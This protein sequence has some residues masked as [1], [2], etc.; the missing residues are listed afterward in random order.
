MRS[1]GF[2]FSEEQPG[3]QTV[4]F[5]GLLAWETV[6][7]ACVKPSGVATDW[8]DLLVAAINAFN[9]ASPGGPLTVGDVAIVVRDWL[10]GHGAISTS[11]PVGLSGS[12]ADKIVALFGASALSDPITSVSGLESKLRKMCGIQLEAP[13]FQLAGIAPTGLG[14]KPRLRVCNTPECSYQQMCE[15]LRPG[16]QAQLGPKEVLICGADSVSV[17]KLPYIDGIWV[18]LCP[19]AV[20]GVIVKFIPEGCPIDGVAIGGPVREGFQPSVNFC[21]ATPPACD[22]RCSRLDCCGGPLDPQKYATR[23]TLIASADGGRVVT[24]DGVRIRP[25][26]GQ[27][28]EPLTP[29]HQLRAGDLLVIPP[30]SRLA[31]RTKDGRVL[32]TPRAGM[33]KDPKTPVVTM[34]I[35]GETAL[36]SRRPDVPPP[37]SLVPR[38]KIKRILETPYAHYGEAGVPLTDARREKY[39][40]STEELNL[41]D[42]RKR[43]LLPEQLRQ[44]AR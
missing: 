3:F 22:P 21:P 23:D 30:G 43:G 11:V 7:G 33:P 36:L 9:P 29:A 4:D 12:E 38:D 16:I 26:G 32:R 18:D 15:A 40:Y 24:A 39:Q 17:V 8:I 13:Q 42:L 20:C 14:P 37:A 41:D 2:Y 27:R 10:L 5:Q 28:F 35:W 44:R 31:I 1:I 25:L 34:M 19:P 6:H